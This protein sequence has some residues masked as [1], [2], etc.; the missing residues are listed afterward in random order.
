MN[1]L[2][3]DVR[4]QQDNIDLALLHCAVKSGAQCQFKPQSVL[5]GR[6]QFH[7][8]IDIPTPLAVID[9]RTEHEIMTSMS[10]AM[11]GRTT[12]VVAQYARTMSPASMTGPGTIRVSPA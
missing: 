7:Q 9:P 5:D 8:Q 1:R 12:F 6:V 11:L 3:V 10:Q 4:C 2:L